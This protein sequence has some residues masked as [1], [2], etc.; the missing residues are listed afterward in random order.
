MIENMK[1]G[2]AGGGVK[3]VGDLLTSK[4]KVAD[5][6]EDSSGGRGTLLTSKSKVTPSSM[7]NTYLS[8]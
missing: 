1:I 2:V 7:Q 4:S 6:I 3:G 8:L 5:A